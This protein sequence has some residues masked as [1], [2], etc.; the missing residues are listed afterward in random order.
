MKQK[1]GVIECGGNNKTFTSGSC[2]P[3]E[4]NLSSN[5]NKKVTN[6]FFK[7]CSNGTKNKASTNPDKNETNMLSTNKTCDIQ[8]LNNH[9]YHQCYQ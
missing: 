2:L 9:K 1:Y 7:G 3:N 8:S 5:D 4:C 6:G